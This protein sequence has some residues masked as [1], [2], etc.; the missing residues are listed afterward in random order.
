MISFFC[1]VRSSRLVGAE[2]T[3]LVR[4]MSVR[5][6]IANMNPPSVDD[7][8]RT[9]SSDERRHNKMRDDFV[10]VVQAVCDLIVD[11]A[12]DAIASG[13]SSFRIFNVCDQLSLPT[14]H[15]SIKPLTFFTGF[16]RPETRSHDRQPFVDAG[17]DISMLSAIQSV[18]HDRQYRVTDVSDPSISYAHVLE[19]GLTPA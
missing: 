14:R 7:L 3:G 10:I 13:K 4:D 11:A 17:I 6:Q 9:A 1:I 5:E 19:I 2:H 18:L 15:T 16:W 8:R 12:R